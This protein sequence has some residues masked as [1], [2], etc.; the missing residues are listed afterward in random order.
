MCISSQ[1]ASSPY[2]LNT[3]SPCDVNNVLSNQ[4]IR[5]V[6]N[7]FFYFCSVFENNSDLVQ[8]E[9][10]LVPLEKNVVQFGCYSYLLLM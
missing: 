6:L 1:L 3:S 9:F 2:V 7:M 5:D 4:H 8:N 10:G